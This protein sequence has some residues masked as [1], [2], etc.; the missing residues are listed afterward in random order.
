MH[1]QG[2]T[3]FS[4]MTFLLLTP[5]VAFAA[6]NTLTKSHAEQRPALLQTTQTYTVQQGD[7]LWGIARKLGVSISDLIAWNHITN[8]NLI[9]PG[10]SITYQALPGDAG[11]STESGQ[12]D[13]TGQ[14]TSENS[15]QT[16]AQGASQATSQA[17]T[18][19]EAPQPLQ[20]QTQAST[21]SG[22]G[23]VPASVAN[24]AEVIPCMLTAYTA[25]PESTGKVP[26]DPGY[27]VTSTG[28]RAI[29]GITVAVDPSIIPYGTKLF[30]PGVG[31]RI[32]E[33]TGG[34]IVGYHIDVFFNNLS[35]ARDFGVHQNVPVYILPSWFPIP[36]F[37]F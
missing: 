19:S 33:D 13:G 17:A 26:G 25:G 36:N 32:A 12:P 34:A 7:T 18:S 29:Q 15:T 22:V 8:P 31:F 20:G 3:W 35:V 28:A 11:E 4:V 6:V 1:R 5:V 24:G 14:P 30:I 21:L 10:E 37:Q 27:D 23:S 16:G 9:L 2:L